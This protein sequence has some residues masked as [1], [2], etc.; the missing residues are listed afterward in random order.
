MACLHDLTVSHKQSGDH[1]DTWWTAAPCNFWACNL[2][3][4]VRARQHDY[5]TIMALKN[6]LLKTCF[7]QSQD[8]INC[9]RSWESW[10]DRSCGWR[11]NSKLAPL[12]RQ[13]RGGPDGWLPYSH[14][15]LLSPED[16]QLCRV[17]ESKG[18]CIEEWLWEAWPYIFLPLWTLLYHPQPRSCSVSLIPP[19]LALISVLF[20]LSDLAFTRAFLRL[21]PC[22]S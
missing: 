5:C 17:G 8:G 9:G 22:C 14:P 6:A 13:L 11:R 4:A 20:L 12:C 3:G 16:A 10:Q 1:G 15:F 7:N 21:S 2:F 19:S 18:W